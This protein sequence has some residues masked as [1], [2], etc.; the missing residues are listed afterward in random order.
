MLVSF[1]VMLHFI[2]LRQGLSLSLELAGSQQALAI[3]LS[4]TPLAL[5]V[6][7]RF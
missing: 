7:P 6:I 3:L 4:L 5:G 1:S 2:P